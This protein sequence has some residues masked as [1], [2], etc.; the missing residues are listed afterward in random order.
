MRYKKYLAVLLAASVFAG[1]TVSAFAGIAEVQETAEDCVTAEETTEGDLSEEEA[2]SG[3]E[4][5]TEETVGEE[6]A[7]YVEETGAEEETQSVSEENTAQYEAASSGEDLPEEEEVTS[8]DSGSE[9]MTADEI[10]EV[11]IEEQEEK[12]QT[13]V[14]EELVTV[15]GSYEC[16]LL[17]TSVDSFTLDGVSSSE[18][19]EAAV[20]IIIENESSGSY[21]AVNKNDA[22]ACSIGC[23]QWHGTRALNLLKSI[24]SADASTSLSLL[25]STLY[26]EIISSSDWSSRTLSSSEATAIANLLGSTAGV[27]AQEA[28]AASDVAEYINRGYS[29]G[30]RNAAALVY[31]ADVEN[32]CGSGGSYKCLTYAANIAGSEEDVTMNEF[33]IAAI[34]YGYRLY[35]SDSS[36]RTI[37]IKRRASVYGTVSAYGWTYYRTGDQQMPYAY[38]WLDGYGVA[39]LQAAL[40][41]YLELELEVDGEYGSATTAAVKAF[42]EEA[43]LTVDGQAGIQT[44]GAL[45]YLLYYEMA[46]NG[47]DTLFTVSGTT[48]AE[49]GLLQYDDSE[50]TAE[51]DTATDIASDEAYLAKASDGN[52]YYYDET[53]NVDTTFTGFCEN[54]YGWFYV[55]N[56]Q[57]SFDTTSVIKGTVDGVTAWWYVKGGKVTFTD[58]LAK[59]SSGWWYIVNGKVDF[60]F[61]GFAEN[62]YGWWYI[63]KGKVSFST[64][65]VMKGTADGTTGWFYVKAGAVQTAYTGLAKNENGWWYLSDGTV[66]F[67]YTGLANNSNGWF[68][69]K[70]GKVDFSY[71]GLAKNSNGWFYVKSGKVDF[72]YTGLAKNSYGW[73]YVKNG[74]VD[75]NYTG[76]AKN[77]AGT[78]YV[79][80]GKVQFGYSGQIQVNGVTY[81]ISGGKVV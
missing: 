38:P 43:S 76:L 70:S 54:E 30:I 58:T 72:S 32:Q 31:Y 28:L 24:I 62:E 34:C 56:G 74:K 61:T 23:L 64:T 63:K 44:I 57:V 79:K 71:T 35:P 25:G 2:A 12:A 3:L 11:L 81:T 50:D 15:S 1:S 40:N 77:S 68:Y 4:A 55:K 5:L 78:W 66:D 69:V 17:Y 51:A 9:E 73:F 80:N 46:V 13:E 22:G 33:Y 10:S 19:L 20:A 8:A 59:N 48:A 16:T 53:G 21:T 52:W 65:S 60:S 67:T 27:A 18:I 7:S 41:T 37:F 39:W 26:N 49:D 45:V 6:A 75:F 42:Q 36:N 14:E 47:A 29:R